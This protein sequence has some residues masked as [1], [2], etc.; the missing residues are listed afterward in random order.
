[1]FNFSSIFLEQVKQIENVSWRVHGRPPF[2]LKILRPMDISARKK[3][4]L[5]EKDTGGDSPL[6]GSAL[7]AM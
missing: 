7:I 5:G 1:M 2:K 3:E 6:Q 4:T